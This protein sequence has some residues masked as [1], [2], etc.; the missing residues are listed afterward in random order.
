[1]LLFAVVENALNTTLKS[2]LIEL[3]KLGTG[4]VWVRDP[5]HDLLRLQPV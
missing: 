3:A 4:G 5:L 2:P 1:M